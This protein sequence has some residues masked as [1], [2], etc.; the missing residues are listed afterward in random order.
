MAGPFLNRKEVSELDM[1]P[2]MVMKKDGKMMV[3]RHGEM[4]AMEMVM[5]MPNGAKV[6][7]DGTVM[8]PDG[9]SRMMMDGEAMTMDGE[10]TTMAEHMGDM[11]DDMA[12]KSGEM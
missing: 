4:K 1:Q 5:T 8:M 7:M 11:K 9:T 10:M 2:D 6:M 3:M 12:D